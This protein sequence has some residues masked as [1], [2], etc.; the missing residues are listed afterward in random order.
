MVSHKDEMHV[1]A[2]ALSAD[3]GD[4]HHT[5][6][7]YLRIICYALPF[8]LLIS[9]LSILTVTAGDYP[10]PPL[11]GS[12]TSIDDTVYPGP[13]DAAPSPT[14]TD[15]SP[16]PSP[17]EQP[18]R[19][20]PQVRA[21]TPATEMPTEPATISSEATPEK[22]SATPVKEATPT[23]GGISEKTETM[24]TPTS[25][26]YLKALPTI[27]GPSPA[28]SPVQTQGPLIPQEL[29]TCSVVFFVL[30]TIVLGLHLARS[31]HGGP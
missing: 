20:T 2:H 8:T 1:V 24:S 19:D 9:L 15:I 29:F 31:E 3:R 30:I 10:A 25:D 4:S 21:T 18:T 12:P 5:P 11:T 26:R 16:E 17:Q 27:V 28:A 23:E 22:V 13:T 7:Y 14:H 6:P